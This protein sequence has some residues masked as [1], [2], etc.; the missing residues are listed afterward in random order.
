MIPIIL[1]DFP[2]SDGNLFDCISVKNEIVV[3]KQT[4]EVLDY[5]VTI[6]PRNE[7]IDNFTFVYR[8][9]DCAPIAFSHY[10]N[11]V[12]EFAS[13]MFSNS[14]PLGEFESSILVSTIKRLTKTTPT[15]QGRK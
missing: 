3:Q 4:T 12:I 7:R 15:L 10:Q 8:I 11:S 14:E 6:Y 9:L 1:T 2:E 13:E 5:M